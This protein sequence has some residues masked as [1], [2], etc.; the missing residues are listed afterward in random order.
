MTKKEDKA[1]ED[2]IQCIV[3]AIREEMMTYF[4]GTCVSR[5]SQDCSVYTDDVPMQTDRR[6]PYYYERREYDRMSP[7]RLILSGVSLAEMRHNDDMVIFP[8]WTVNRSPEFKEIHRQI[9]AFFHK[10]L[11]GV[12][13]KEDHSLMP[14]DEARVS[15]RELILQAVNR[16]EEDQLAVHQREM[17]NRFQ[18]A[19][20]F[21][22]IAGS[23]T[24]FPT[25]EWDTVEIT[26]TTTAFGTGLAVDYELDDDL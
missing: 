13:L 2:G 12:Q 21:Y 25:V 17:L 5:L 6:R 4:K 9:K 1:I 7:R 15:D 16:E 3:M 10:Y 24:G 26:R 8:I 20:N 18:R 22:T 11:Q 19:N 14:I 23:T